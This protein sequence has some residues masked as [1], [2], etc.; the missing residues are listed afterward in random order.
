MKILS[1]SLQNFASYE[2]LEFDFSNQGLCLIEGPTGSG[3]STLCDF[4][5]W[6]L[7]GKTAK[8]GSVDEIL[9]W[10]G[11]KVTSGTIY[12]EDGLEITRIRGPKAKDNDLYFLYENDTGTVSAQRGKDLQD[13]QKLINNLLGVDSDLYLAG[14]YFHE[15]SQTAQFFNTTAKNRREI[16]EQLTDLSLAIKLHSNINEN[17]KTLAKEVFDIQTKVKIISSNIDQLNSLQES[18]NTRAER[19]EA[20][21]KKTIE[22]TVACYDKFEK[23]RKKLLSNKCGACGTVLSEPKELVDYSENPHLARLSE[24]ESEKNPHAGAVKDFT[25]AIKNKNDELLVLKN[26]ENELEIKYCDLEILEDIVSDFRSTIVRNA[27][28]YVE[29]TTNTLLTDHFDAEIKMTMSAEDADK[30]QVEIT[31]D[32][33]K[34]VYNQ[35]S[36]GQRQIL[37]L[38]FGVAVMKC[39]SNNSGIKFHQVW[40]DEAL[41]GL[42]E[43]MK[44]KAFGLLNTL[45]LE[46]ESIFVVEHSNELKA[47]FNTKYHVKLINGSSQIEKA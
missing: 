33:N 38:C 47:M 24:L 43:T 30:I 11:D 22:H 21:H 35:L 46:Y 23:G 17:T 13:T 2:S 19:W 25:G 28:S 36:K 27:I 42:D 8:N 5:P 4:I 41:D 6:I 39:V 26:K 14:A 12:F 29:T 40:F 18:E 16:L 37:K 44:A 3:K 45:Q 15:F 7:F 9:S 1:C 31:K 34:C 32:G 10:P 20:S